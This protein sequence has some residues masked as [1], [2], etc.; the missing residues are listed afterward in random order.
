MKHLMSLSTI[1]LIKMLIVLVLL[2]VPPWVNFRKYI[3][4]GRIRINEFFLTLIFILY[5]IATLFTEN[6]MP[7]IIVVM[8]L[9]IENKN[10][11]FNDEDF[12]FRKLGK[13]KGK[14]FLYSIEFKIFITFIN[15]AVVVVLQKFNV[16][17]ENQ[18][19]T[20]ELL[21]SNWIQTAIYLIMIVI[22]A[23]ILEEFIFRHLIYSNLAKKIG[24]VFAAIISSLLFTIPHYNIAGSVSFFGVGLFN[25]YLYDKY[26]YRA[27]VINHFVF[28]FTSAFLML[29]MKGFHVNIGI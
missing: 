17:I 15:A 14:I 27:S 26:G 20:K 9:Y 29:L 13:N 18:E 25:C 4:H 22:I 19:V 24:V 12:Y 11:D 21:Q 2:A 6:L 16:P 23:P 5:L 7:F 8:T 28:N 3:K 10:R 1:D